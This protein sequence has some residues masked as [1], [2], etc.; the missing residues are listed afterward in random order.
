MSGF[1]FPQ[2]ENFLCPCN[3]FNYLFFITGN[4]EQY[5]LY[6]PANGKHSS[7]AEVSEC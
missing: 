3:F 4:R 1:R 5:Y 7:Y 2:Q 6:K